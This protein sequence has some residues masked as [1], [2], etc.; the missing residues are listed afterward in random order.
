MKVVKK[1]KFAFAEGLVTLEQGGEDQK[2]H[3]VLVNVDI[4]VDSEN[5]HSTVFENNGSK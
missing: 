5:L 2:Q 1:V 3:D 4:F